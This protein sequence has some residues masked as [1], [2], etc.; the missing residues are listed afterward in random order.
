MSE[1]TKFKIKKLN[2]DTKLFLGTNYF[3]QP[4]KFFFKKK[5]INDKIK[6]VFV[7][8]LDHQIRLMRQLNLL[9]QLGN[10]KKIKFFILIGKN[11]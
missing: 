2:P 7:F 9:M 10:F 3:I 5:K 6:K 1:K 8:F 4:K 11:K